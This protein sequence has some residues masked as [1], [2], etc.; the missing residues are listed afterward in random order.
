M[1]DINPEVQIFPLRLVSEDRAKALLA[2]L[3]TI[4]NVKKTEYKG[5][6]SQDKSVFK[7]GWIW[8]ELATE[9]ESVLGEIKDVCDRQL[10]FG[11]DIQRGRFTKYRATTADYL[12]GSVKEE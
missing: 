11:Y 1:S 2:D 6:L 3:N 7:V 4:D 8:V 9:D 12:R 10:P 5:F